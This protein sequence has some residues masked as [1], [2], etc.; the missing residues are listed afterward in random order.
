M[1]PA[2]L[3]VYL[4]RPRH[5]GMP[6]FSAGRI[7]FAYLVAG[8]I[9]IL[10]SDHVIASLTPNQAWQER[11]SVVKGWAF[12]LITGGFLYGMLRRQLRTSAAHEE[13]LRLFIAH[14]P[15]ALAMLDR[16]FRYVAVSQR[17]LDD[18]GMKDQVLAGRSHYE[19]FPEIPESWRQ[20]HRRSLAGEFIN[21]EAERFVRVDGSV[22]WIRWQTLPWYDGGGQVGGILI[23]TEDVTER[24]EAE[25]E[26]IDSQARL[27][28]ALDCG[29]VGTWNWDLVTGAF[30]CDDGI[31]RLTGRRRE[32]LVRGGTEFYKSCIHADDYS[33]VDEEIRA[34]VKGG[35]EFFSEYRIV[36]PD[37]V[38]LWVKD[39]ASVVRDAAGNP[40][41]M[42]GACVD[43]S[44]VKRIERA[45]HDSEDRF[46]EV[47]ET[48]REVFWITDIAKNRILYVSPGYEEIWGR[49]CGELY[50][51]GRA[52]VEAIHED[53]R[54]RVLEAAVSKQAAGTYD[55]TYRIV[56]PDKSIRWVRDR[57]YPV[58]DET[59]A[60]VRIVGTAADVTER[61]K[62][63][64][65]FLHAQRLEAIGTLASGVAHDLNNILAPLF[66]I[67]P[68]LK[69]KLQDPADLKLLSM[70]EQ[71][72]Q[73]GANVVRQLL[74]F[75]RGI[76]GERGPLQLRHLV[77]EM[78]AI[79]LETF[80]REIGIVQQ[81]P[82]EI[83]TVVGDATQLHQVL[84][85]LCVN[86]RDAMPEGGKLSVSVRETE[87]SP[88]DVGEHPG[89][90]PGR[91]V[92][93]TVRDTGY[94]IPPEIRARIFEPFFTTKEIGKGTGLGLSTV[95]GIVRS[96]GGFII[97]DSEEGVGSAFHV[98]LPAAVALEAPTAA[99]PRPAPRGSGELVLIV[100]DEQAVREA[101]QQVLKMHGYT[102]VAASN[103]REALSLY[104]EHGDRIQAVVTDLMMPEM[105]G[106]ALVRA[107]RELDPELAILAATGLE[108]G[109]Q[110]EAL[111][112]QRVDGFL[113]K[114][115]SSFELLESLQRAL[116]RLQRRS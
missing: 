25:R 67:A 85:N 88:D 27:R 53:D 35:N 41:R 61:K 87:L 111:R 78:A 47:V 82:A 42:I 103:G 58:R 72:G 37:G 112:D 116:R 115:Y 18:Y 28:L 39:Q 19:V 66:M 93:L 17:W 6:T 50:R 65:Q 84:M 36:R 34:A 29:H 9:W 2:S 1:N 56:R 57:A 16:D 102:V 20:I 44:A 52:W 89:A 104:L 51:S 54:E 13:K 62:L 63:E 114:P 23:S 70:L 95:L 109:E 96:H 94:G 12:V 40:L 64:E 83:S 48:I 106:V 3:A 46:R 7:V 79:M 91:Y 71:T 92:V 49:P 60:V 76:A 4:F 77:K 73:R 15:V 26:L 59:G 33:I 43:I 68:L 90:K 105:G 108:S 22:Q 30:D 45:L 81:L 5:K 107:L 31:A 99:A 69:S 24:V 80:P 14:A 55:E 101:M 110:S 74:T 21:E 97:L 8:M 38:V 98:H 75:S 86:A 32:E 113:P 11:L 10:L 100:D